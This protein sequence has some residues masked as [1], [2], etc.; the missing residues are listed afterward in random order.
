V[1]SKMAWTFSRGLSRHR[2]IM[3]AAQNLNSSVET[4][5][6][7]ELSYIPTMRDRSGCETN[8]P[9]ARHVKGDL[10]GFVPLNFETDRI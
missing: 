9:A 7:A 6:R 8:P 4:P 2:E 1:S 10:L 3:N 5:V